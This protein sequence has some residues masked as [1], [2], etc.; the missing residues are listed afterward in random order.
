MAQAR[1]LNF[2]QPWGKKSPVGSLQLANLTCKL[3]FGNC[4]LISKMKCIKLKILKT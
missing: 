1:Y 2:N 3:P 4:K